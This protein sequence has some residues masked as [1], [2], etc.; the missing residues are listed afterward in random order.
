MT[1]KTIITDKDTTYI[2][3]KRPLTEEEERIVKDVMDQAWEEEYGKEEAQP[4]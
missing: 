3:S 2:D 4:E 1:G